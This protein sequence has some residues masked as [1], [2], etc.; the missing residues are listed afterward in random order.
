MLTR[1]ISKSIRR[2][3]KRLLSKPSEG[4]EDK[5]LKSRTNK[6]KMSS[7]IERIGKPNKNEDYLADLE[8]PSLCYKLDFHNINLEHYRDLDQK[9]KMTSGY[10]MMQ[11]E[12]FPRM[13]IMKIGL[14]MLRKL[15]ALPK[16]FIFRIYMGI[17]F[18]DLF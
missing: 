4:L 11:V 15:E 17:L 10:A 14:I 5:E 8:D 12:P 9:I 3:P 2:L 18:Y 16:T 13:K 7:M 1:F 6:N